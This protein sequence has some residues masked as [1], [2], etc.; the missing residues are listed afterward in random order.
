MHRASL[1]L[2]AIQR[3]EVVQT[4]LAGDFALK[5]FLPIE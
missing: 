3:L 5:L 1:K 4:A 2:L